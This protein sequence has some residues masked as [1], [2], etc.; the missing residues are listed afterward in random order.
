M[1]DYEPSATPGLSKERKIGFVL[2]LIF[3]LLTVSLGILQI[4]NNLYAPFALNNQ[5]P[6]T[7]RDEV[8]SVEALRLRDTDRDGL[9]DFDEA[10][11]YNTSR[12]IADTDSDGQTDGQEIAAGTNPLCAEGKPC[13]AEGEEAGSG[14]NTAA[15]LESLRALDPGPP[16]ADLEGLL[17]NPAQV[18][19]MLIDAGVDAALVAR[20]SDKDLLVMVNQVINATS[21]VAQLQA[22]REAATNTQ[23]Q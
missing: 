10:Y 18:R 17:T 9:T 22:L 14:G 16:P 13:V 1:P 4:R 8:N 5:V 15:T 3:A 21:T 7:L 19:Q 12:Y 11:V 2:L 23:R 6:A 20:I